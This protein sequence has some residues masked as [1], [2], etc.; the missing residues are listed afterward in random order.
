MVVSNN[1]SHYDIENKLAEFHHHKRIPHIIFHGPPA[2][3]KKYILMKFLKLVYGDEH[4]LHSNVMFV[5]CAHGKGIKFIRDELKFFAKTNTQ[6]VNFKSIVMLNAEQLTVDAQSAM[7]RCIEQYSNNTRFFIVI[8]NKSKLLVPILS[9]FC[10]IYVPPFFDANG[11]PVSLTQQEFQTR[12][13]LKTIEQQKQN[14]I[15][16]IISTYMPKKWYVKQKKTSQKC[17]NID[18]IQLD[19]LSIGE[20]LYEEGYSVQDFVKWI[21][22][23]SYW[24]DIVK[25]SIGLE[26]MKVKT[27]FRCEKLLFLYIFNSLYSSI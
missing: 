13:D 25:S 16:T 5:N 10:E 20:K 15:S 18:A 1:I 21:Q 27:E 6:G 2:S 7:R 4:K 12:Y 8:H 19:M 14:N 9:R 24:D 17:N 11:N 23:Q 22:K 26:Y 3:G